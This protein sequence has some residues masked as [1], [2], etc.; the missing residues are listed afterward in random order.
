[1]NKHVF[2]KDSSGGWY[3]DLPEFL[4]QGGSKG[5]L[6][7]GAGADTMLDIIAQGKSRVAL[8][9]S[10][11]PFDGA[12]ELSLIQ[13]RDPSVGGGDYIMSLHDGEVI[14]YRMWLCGVTEFVFGYMPQRIYLK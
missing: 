4:V 14:N 9:L 10:D 7:M 3:I 5:N 6:A 12:D 2:Y 11:M 13:L 8:Q 1:M